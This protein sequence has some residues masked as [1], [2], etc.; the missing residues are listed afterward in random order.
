M[1]GLRRPRR[2]GVIE[3]GSDGS[4]ELQPIVRLWAV[5]L[6]SS[7]FNIRDDALG[8]GIIYFVN[9][10]KALP[11]GSN[12]AAAL[13]MDQVLRYGGLVQ[14]QAFLHVLAIKDGLDWH[15]IQ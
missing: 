1:K 13:E 3:S 15:V 9:H 4:T 5:F 14:P 12:D 11:G 2:I 10:F 7:L 8:P 6:F